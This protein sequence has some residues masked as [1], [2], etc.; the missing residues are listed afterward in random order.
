VRD[1][2]GA[3]AGSEGTGEHRGDPVGEEVLAFP[4][5]DGAHP[6]QVRGQEGAV[7]GHHEEERPAAPVRGQR[8][9]E[10]EHLLHHLGRDHHHAAGAGDHRGLL[11][12][13]VRTDADDVHVRNRI[14]QAGFAFDDDEGARGRDQGF[15]ATWAKHAAR[16]D[17]LPSTA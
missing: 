7:R 8:G 15:S 17:G 2:L 3:D 4:D 5:H 13:F 1:L 6:E 16:Q 9:P 12:D 14:R 10:G 11:A